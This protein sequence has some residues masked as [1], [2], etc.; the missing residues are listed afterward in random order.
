M[1]LRKVHD[2]L[3]QDPS[4]SERKKTELAAGYPCETESD[5]AEWLTKLLMFGM[6]RP[7]QAR[8]V[9]KL[10]LLASGAGSPLVRGYVLAEPPRPCAWFC[11]RENDL[12]A[13]H[14]A[15]T[16]HGAVF[17]Y[18]IPGIGKSELT[19]SYAA[20]HRKEY[21]NIL[22][23]PYTGDLRQ[24]IASLDFADDLPGEPI[25]MLSLIHI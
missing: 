3:V 25:E 19:K 16:E 2:L 10:N 8:D 21:T 4:I 14:A 18:G 11:G 20:Q 13:L 6:E 17:L 24:G 9:R 1:A 23:L 22:Y 12:D 7:F 5:A 15:L